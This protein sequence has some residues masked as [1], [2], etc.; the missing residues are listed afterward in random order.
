MPYPN[1]PVIELSELEE[2][3]NY[4]KY[5]DYLKAASI[6]YYNS[7]GSPYTN[8]IIDDITFEERLKKA[9]RFFAS[10]GVGEITQ[11]LGN[12]NVIEDIENGVA[13]YCGSYYEEMNTNLR[14]KLDEK[15]ILLDRTLDF[16]EILENYRTLKNLRNPSAI[17]TYI[18]NTLNAFTKITPSSNT[19]YVFRCYKKLHNG[20]PLLDPQNNILPRIYLNQ[21][22]ST[23]ILL[24]LADWWC[25]PTPINPENTTSARH[26]NIGDN[27]IICIEIPIGTRG[28]SII[29]YYGL[30]DKTLTTEY[31]EYEYLL[32]PGGFLEYTTRTYTYTSVSRKQLRTALR[33]NPDELEP[34]PNLPMTFD[35]PIYTYMSNVKQNATYKEILYTKYS[36]ILPKVKNMLTRGLTVVK[37]VFNYARDKLASA[38]NSMRGYNNLAEGKTRRKLKKKQKQTRKHTLK[39]RKNKQKKRKN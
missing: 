5:D 19:F 24:R 18:Y 7:L 10:K 6:D 8:D 20:A 26:P 4:D 30:V 12:F 29:N 39:Q 25:T 22:T 9:F 28:I 35:I 15:N 38:R 13:K 14:R 23:S 33:E 27:T 32:P 17:N 2:Y 1:F 21:F 36:Y 3:N 16:N 11:I 37:S 31:S 34:F